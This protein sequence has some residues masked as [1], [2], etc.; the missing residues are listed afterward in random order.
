MKVGSLPADRALPEPAESFSRSW[1]TS[2]DVTPASDTPR[3]RPSRAQPP[4]SSD[5]DNAPATITDPQT[6]N[7]DFPPSIVQPRTQR[8]RRR[9]H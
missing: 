1:S 9:H 6:F 4:N 7:Q 2:P 5:A 3:P 8:Q